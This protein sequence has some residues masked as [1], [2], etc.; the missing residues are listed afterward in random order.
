MINREIPCRRRNLT[1]SFLVSALLMVA[2]SS[3]YGQTPQQTNRSIDNSEVDEVIDSVLSGFNIHYLYPDVAED[4]SAHVRKK[5]KD[6]EYYDVPNLEELTGLLTEDLREISQDRH[7]WISLMS[8]EDLNPT[9]GDT[10]TDEQIAARSRRNFFFKKVEW[11]PGNVGYL[12]LDRFDDPIH[13]GPTAVAAMN[14]LANCAAVIIDL[15]H[16]G[17]GEEK[18]VRLIAS[19]FLKEPALLTSLYFTET[20]SL[21]QSWTYAYVPGR[22]LIDADLYILT[23]EGTGSGAEAFSYALKNLGRATV[24]GQTTGGAAHWAE[25]YDFPNLQVRAKIPIARP[26]NPITKTSWE[27]VGVAPTIE[28]SAEKAL[29][30]AYLEALENVRERTA[31]EIELAVIDWAIDGAKCQ[32]SPPQ[33]SVETLEQYVGTYGPRKITLEND[34]LHY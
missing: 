20:D 14:F 25:Y 7:I 5:Q 4:M 11:L 19:Y 6:R 32:I 34:V 24:V 1:I 33:L 27:R 18:M 9:I 29:D 3:L 26:I 8:P 22:K 16:N 10:L 13:A 17:G 30:V 2:C 23:S 12:R 15:R 21:E 28:A 31:R